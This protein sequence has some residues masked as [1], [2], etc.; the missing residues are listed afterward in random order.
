[1]IFVPL[2]DDDVW[3]LDVG[4]ALSTTAWRLSVAA[5]VVTWRGGVSGRADI[6][7]FAAHL[8]PRRFAG[9][10]VDECELLVLWFKASESLPF[11]VT[12][13]ELLLLILV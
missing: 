3:Q 5:H 6:T 9:S 8:R 4:C 1:M 10:C 11:F 13:F 12:L 7:Q 2:Q